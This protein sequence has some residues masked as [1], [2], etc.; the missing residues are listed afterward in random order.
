VKVA[1]LQ[2][3]LNQEPLAPRR[4]PLEPLHLQQVSLLALR[5]KHMLI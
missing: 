5:G 2:W 3:M 1:R 4:D